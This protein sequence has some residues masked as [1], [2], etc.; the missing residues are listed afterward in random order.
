MTTLNRQLSQILLLFDCF[1]LGRN[2]LGEVALV[3]Q[4]E[5]SFPLYASVLVPYLNLLEL[6]FL[7]NLLLYLLKEHLLL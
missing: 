4:H 2:Q 1:L 5:I 7:L 6:L 3:L